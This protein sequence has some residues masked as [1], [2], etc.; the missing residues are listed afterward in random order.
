M[1]PYSKETV[2]GRDYVLSEEIGDLV[3]FQ[4]VNGQE[5]PPIP[6]FDGDKY[7]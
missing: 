3:E 2:K 1:I 4:L 6:L 5:Y 7:S